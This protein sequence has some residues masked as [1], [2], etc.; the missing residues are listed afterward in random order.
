M[1]FTY[2]MVEWLRRLTVN[3]LGSASADSNS[4]I[5]VFLIDSMV[6]GIS[7]CSLNSLIRFQI[8]EKA[9]ILKTS[10]ST[11]MENLQKEKITEERITNSEMFCMAI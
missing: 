2:N 6:K 1:A 4:K 9:G 8:T 10:A 11:F 7:I 3:P 5:V